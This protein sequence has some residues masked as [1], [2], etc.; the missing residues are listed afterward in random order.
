MTVV[1]IQRLETEIEM[2]IPE[3]PMSEGVVSQGK[4]TKP[5]KR[6]FQVR[7]LL[8]ASDAEV[9]GPVCGAG[10]LPRFA[11]SAPCRSIDGSQ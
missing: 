5:F 9:F 7:D 6:S 10:G 2:E 11:L 1:Q 8:R 4:L 3:S